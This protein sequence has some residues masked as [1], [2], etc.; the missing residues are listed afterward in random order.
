MNKAFILHLIEKIAIIGF[1]I[2][3]YLEKLE[4]IRSVKASNFESYA[5][6]VLFQ[7]S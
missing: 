6:M 3:I 4:E 2:Y 7:K 1:I 5:K